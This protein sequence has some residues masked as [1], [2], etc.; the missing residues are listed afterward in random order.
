MMRA[1]TGEKLTP[2]VN[3]DP[4]NVAAGLRRLTILGY[5]SANAHMEVEYNLMRWARGEEA[6]ADHS[7]AD[8]L[9]GVSYTDWRVCLTS[10]IAQAKSRKGEQ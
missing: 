5:D 10:A 8:S 1:F 4:V 9:S 6:Q 7:M 3:V 2:G